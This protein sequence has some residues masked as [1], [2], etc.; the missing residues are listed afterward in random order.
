[1]RRVREIADPTLVS[2]SQISL[3]QQR[4][5]VRSTSR[6]PHNNP[7]LG[8]AVLHSHTGQRARA[9]GQG[10]RGCAVTAAAETKR[11][12]GQGRQQRLSA[13]APRGRSKAPSRPGPGPSTQTLP[14]VT[15]RR[16]RGA[17]RRASVCGH[18]LTEPEKQ[19][20]GQ[21]PAVLEKGDSGFPPITAWE[22][23][24]WM[25]GGLISVPILL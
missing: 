10:L 16:E 8:A 3:G 4:M 23:I 14:P 9:R 5:P 12:W 1:M 11:G 25:N 7:D 15:S 18:V 21:D 2:P 13:A 17:G 6:S 22:G 20:A 19:Q 24:S